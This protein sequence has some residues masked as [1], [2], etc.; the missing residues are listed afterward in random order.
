MSK[1]QSSQ[2]LIKKIEKVLQNHPGDMDECL[3]ATAHHF[4]ATVQLYQ[5]YQGEHDEI[6]YRSVVLK[7]L[8]AY[9][10]ANPFPKGQ[11][12]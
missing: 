11:P 9:L 4:F 6:V 1:N 5:I 12:S 7:L 2:Q 8:D 3:A 10:K